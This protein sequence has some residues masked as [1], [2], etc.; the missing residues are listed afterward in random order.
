MAENDETEQ[1]RKNREAEQRRYQTEKSSKERDKQEAEA[2]KA[3]LELKIERL[4]EAYSKIHAVKGSTEELC[5]GVQNQG[6]AMTEWIGQKFNVYGS[7][8]GGDFKD[9]YKTYI[10]DLDYTQDEI[11]REIARLQTQAAE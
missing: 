4:K 1:H 5:Y 3:A 2:A 9:Y 8:I 6:K 11:N 7:F 10:N